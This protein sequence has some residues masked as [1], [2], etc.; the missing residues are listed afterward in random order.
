MAMTKPQIPDSNSVIDRQIGWKKWIWFALILALAAALRLYRLD[1]VPPG[2]T[3]DEANNVHDAVSILH[4]ARPY[5]FPV[6]QGKEPLYPYSVALVMAIAGPSPYAMR[7]TSAFWGL[8]LVVLT[9]LWAKRAFNYPVALWTAAGLAL[10]FWGV[11]T[12]RVGLRAIML[13]VFFVASTLVSRLTDR[14]TSDDSDPRHPY[15]HAIFAGLLLGL[16]FYTYLAARVMPAIPL[17]FGFYI[18]GGARDR[19]QQYWRGWL[20]MLIVA[21]CVAAPLFLYLR[22]HPAA[23]IRMGQL[24]R[25]LRAFLSGDPAPL[26]GNVLQTLRAFS[27]QG[28]GFIPYNLPGRP[29]LDP[30]MSLLFYAG[31]AIALRRW[32]DPAYAFVLLW[33]VIGFFPALA[34]GVDAAH[35][36]AIGAQPV[37]FVFPALTLESLRSIRVSHLRLSWLIGGF[38]L[39]LG[40]FLT[41]QDYFARWSD[42]P[43]VRVHYHVDLMAIADMLRDWEK[44]KPVAISAFYPNQYH[45]PRIVE[46]ALGEDSPP[47]R[48]FDGRHGL[49]LP[50]TS[51]IGLI[52]P[53]A[54][55]LDETLWALI[56]PQVTLLKQVNLR[57][58]DFSPSYDVYQWSATNPLDTLRPAMTVPTQPAWLPVDVGKHL[59]FQG[60]QLDGWTGNPSS[61]FAVLT[62][63]QVEAP[64]PSDR[65]AVVFVQ[66]LDGENQVVAQQDRLDAPSWEWQSGDVFLQLHR[67]QLPTEALP[68][69]YTLIAGVYT[70]PDRVDAVL[71]GHEPDLTMPRL[72]IQ[73]GEELLG[74]HLVLSVLEIR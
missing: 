13:P 50:S 47:V 23:D 68:G 70:V 43:D 5:Y 20:V 67:L 45:D 28:D 24:D 55:P 22:A 64:L 54:I 29:I 39:L 40:A 38:A 59:D 14:H 44:D 65:D 42:D 69:T 60:Y 62:L 37:L 53:A 72:S 74:D 58:D 15:P 16:T 8:L 1:S 66:L 7:L 4:G 61:Q 25:P 12:S 33:L 27:F 73:A 17:L 36:R 9:Y 19:W 35:L 31:L 6:A 63:W 51:T 41:V 18:F 30:L 11:S 2:L 10:S 49:I 46:A 34:T 3:H 57:P 32:R 26:L 48:W 56:E 21:A 71:A 52:L